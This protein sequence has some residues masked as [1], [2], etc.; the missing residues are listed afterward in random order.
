MNESWPA[1]SVMGLPETGASISAAPRAVI[2]APSSRVT[3]GLTVLISAHTAP[4]R[5]PAITP[6]GPSAIARSALSSVTMLR[7]AS[8]PSATARGDFSSTRP[9]AT[10]ARALSAVRL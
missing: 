2:A 4:G 5:S 8:T 9:A 1:S 10:S 7:T 3:S 6:S